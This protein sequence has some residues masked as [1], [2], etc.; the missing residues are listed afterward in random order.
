MST[1]FLGV[2]FEHV[3]TVLLLPV[4]ITEFVFNYLQISYR[5]LSSASL[6]VA[7]FVLSCTVCKRFMF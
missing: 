6:Y 2:Y 4:L 3:G 5:F 7:S 1:H